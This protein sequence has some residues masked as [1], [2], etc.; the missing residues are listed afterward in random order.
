MTTTQLS[1][2]SILQ[3]IFCPADVR[4]I[5][6][7]NSLSK[8]QGHLL[9]LARDPS[10]F[11]AGYLPPQYHFQHVTLVSRKAARGIKLASHILQLEILNP[12]FPRYS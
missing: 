7:D 1:L 3:V 11:F 10:A 4:V 2:F 12:V 9:C 5:N 8:N 6:Y